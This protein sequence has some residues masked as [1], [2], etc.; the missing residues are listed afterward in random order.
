MHLNH[1]DVWRDF[2]IGF[3]DALL[4]E[5]NQYGMELYNFTG[6]GWI[7]LFPD[8]IPTDL[9]CRSLRVISMSFH[10]Q[11]R[12]SIDTLLGIRLPAIGLTFG[13]DS[14]ELVSLTMNERR[15]YLG[16]AINVACRLQSCA[17]DFDGGPANKAVF[18]MNSFN[19]PGILPPAAPIERRKVILRNSNPP[20]VECFVFETYPAA[21]DPDFTGGMKALAGPRLKPLSSL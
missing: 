5:G 8:N 4:H 14:G 6:D 10:A 9:V 19:R 11:F 2:L 16:R 12:F 20:E 15:E 7:L 1:E 18:S 3:K 13:I 17:K 21:N